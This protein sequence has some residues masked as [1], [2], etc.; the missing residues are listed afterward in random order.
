MG[1]GGDGEIK[2]FYAHSNADAVYFGLGWSNGGDHSCV[3]DFMTMG[4]GQFCYKEDG[5]GAGWH[6]GADASG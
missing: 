2:R 4:D 6:A 3:C 5:A 1:G